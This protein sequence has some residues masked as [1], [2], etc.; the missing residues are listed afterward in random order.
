[1]AGRYISPEMLS[2]I[3]FWAMKENLSIQFVYPDKPLPDILRPLI[4]S[5]DHTNLVP[6][7]HEDNDLLNKAD[8]IVSNNVDLSNKFV[9][10]IYILR[11][12][13]NELI[14]SAD[15][16]KGLIRQSVKV[17]VVITDIEKFSK[18]SIGAYRVFLEEMSGFVASEIT[19]GHNV[20]FNL[21][22]DRMMLQTMNNCN[23]GFESVAASIDG[24][25]Y[26]CPA[27]IGNEQFKCGDVNAGFDAPNL[28]LYRIDNAPI[29][30]I[31]DAFQ[32]KRCVWLNSALTHEVNT[33]GWQQCV[34]SHLEREAA[35]KTLAHI[36]K[37][38][39]DYLPAIELPAIDYIDPFTK[40]EQL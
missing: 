18:E 31:C 17:N 8:V 40:I 12:S 10:K 7:T 6:E 25:L 21:V 16:L 13:F 38:V 24:V 26:P 35:R 22:T 39:P 27:F 34:I 14:A 11:L 33:P 19:N 2:G 29:C 36:R 20:Q 23:A 30:K 9:N 37:Q 5:I 15:N 32:C 4:Q 3:I 28:R 1:M